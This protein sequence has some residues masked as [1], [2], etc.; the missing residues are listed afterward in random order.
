MVGLRDT[1]VSLKL[2]MD[3]ELTL[4]KAVTAAQQTKTVKLQPSI[5]HGKP[6]S[7]ASRCG[8]RSLVKSHFLRIT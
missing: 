5:I 8:R 2:H 6:T 4:E 1:I 3:A 7:I